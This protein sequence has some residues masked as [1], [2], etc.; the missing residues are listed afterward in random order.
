MVAELVRVAIL[1]APDALSLG[2]TVGH[3]TFRVGKELRNREGQGKKADPD[4]SETHHQADGRVELE[5]AQEPTIKIRS[6]PM[7]A[8]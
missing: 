2:G 8:P 4:G 7:I 1:N 6:W 5:Q 3:T